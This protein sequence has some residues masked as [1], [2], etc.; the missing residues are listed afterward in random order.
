MSQTLHQLLSDDPVAVED[1]LAFF[2]A[3]DKILLAAEGV[4]LLAGG[5]QQFVDASQGESG[6]SI[7][8]VSADVAARGLLSM[9]TSCQLLEDE[10]W[11]EQVCSHDVVLSWK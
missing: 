4:G 9:A 11:V 10:Q 8:A 3:G 5:N 6:I 7:A 1:C 2:R